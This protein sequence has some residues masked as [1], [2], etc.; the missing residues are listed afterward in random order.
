M[1]IFTD[2]LRLGVGN[3]IDELHSSMGETLSA[4]AGEAV[5]SLPSV[6]F[7][8]IVELGISKGDRIPLPQTDALG[9][10]TGN[11]DPVSSS[12]PES[13]AVTDVPMDQ[14]RARVKEA[15]LDRILH[16][17]DAPSIRAPALDIMLQRARE[18]NE[19]QA[20]IA[21]GPDGFVA[22][23]LGMGTSLLVSAIDPL[24]IAAA[25]IPVVGEARY[26]KL[27]AN[28]GEGVLARASVRAG[29]GA[30]SGA[31]GTAVVEPLEYLARNQE[32]QDYTMAEALRSVMFGA[33]LGGVLHSG[34]G[35]VA[36][37]YRSRKGKPLYPF[38]PGEA[39]ERPA[40]PQGEAPASAMPFGDTKPAGE[41]VQPAYTAPAAAAPTIPAA[42]ESSVPAAAA[43]APPSLLEFIA[44][45]GG[46]SEKDPL[47][48]DLLQSFGG[49]SPSIPGKGR[50]RLVRPDGKS[51]DELREAAVEAGYLQDPARQHG[52]VTESTIDDLLQAV[53]AEARGTKQFPAGADGARS[54]AEQAHLDEQ[55]QALHERHVTG[56]K[57]D[58]EAAI[59]EFGITAPIRRQFAQRAFKIMETEGSGDARDAVFRTLEE[60]DY[61]P[62]GKHP[63]MAGL[64]DLPPRAR[65]DTL[66]ASI[67]NLIE[68]EPVRAGEMLH[69]AARTDPR[70]AES[71]DLW[72]GP[73]SPSRGGTDHAV[74]KDWFAGSQVID[75]AGRPNPVFHGTTAEF[76]QFDKSKLGFETGA[77]SARE[78]FFFTEDPELARS[79]G[80]TWDPYKEV[81]LINA[82]NKATL[83]HYE[84][85]NEGV[86]GLFGKSAKKEGKVATAFLKAERPLVIDYAG[87]EYREVSFYDAIQKAKAEGYDSVLFKNAVDQGFDETLGHRP[88]N[89]W[90]VFEPDQV[91]I[92]KFDK[93]D[94][95][96]GADRAL[97][98]RIAAGGRVDLTG[99]DVDATWHE[100]ADRKPDFDEPA[101]VEASRAADAMPAPELLAAKPSARV[102]AAEKALADAEAQYKAN[103]A[104]IPDEIKQKLDHELAKLD[105]EASDRAEV[106]Q[107]GAACLAAAVGA[108]A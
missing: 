18:R 75:E 46:I 37:M 63:V 9:N 58:I 27:M 62:T 101:V 72:N 13:P 32:G 90:A 85:F 44:D 70:I 35:A 81:P 20:T 30:A 11:P 60:F 34:G 76:K 68:G 10:V 88:A 41:A 69:A 22:G 106:I 73:K 17:P 61:Q 47:L 64:D 82:L 40:A 39:F 67:A 95:F 16:L 103:E 102:A 25:F 96:T 4:T 108:M 5:E 83:G 31:V 19:R 53:D 71:L 49:K 91:K 80:V 23:A 55:Q 98:D 57:A 24:N 38:G 6:S 65:E 29:V 52:G 66:R 59:D 97:V 15:G 93:A 105:V 84:K 86:L 94:G 77:P 7:S 56:T 104:Y 26:A 92:A 28:A 8:H 79:Y 33:A 45:R 2:G 36:D 54:K 48:A 1:T 87:N 74:F 78:A 107:R 14:A 100:L 99:R 51:L 3:G 50:G 12:P 89:V 42:A 21:R 43:K